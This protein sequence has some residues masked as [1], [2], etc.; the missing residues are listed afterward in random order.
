[1]LLT[2]G[3][4]GSA[5][6]AQ[7]LAAEL[8]EHVGLVAL[9]I[10]GPTDAEFV[11]R[12]GTHAG[13]EEFPNS[14]VAKQAHRVNAVV[15]AVEVSD[16]EDGLGARCPH[17][18]RRAGHIAHRA[19]IGAHMRAEDL[20]KLL[21]TTLIEQ[22]A[23]DLPDSRGKAVGVVGL[24]LDAI[25]PGRQDAIVHRLPDVAPQATPDTIGFMLKV[26][27]L[28]VLE[29]NAHRVGKR[30]HGPNAQAIRLDVLPEHIVGLLVA[31]IGQ[32]PARSG[33]SAGGSG[34]HGWSSLVASSLRK[35]RSIAVRGMSIHAGRLRAS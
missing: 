22:K 24:V 34:A 18:E 35:S 5:T 13:N 12:A 26:E 33:K 15:P 7:H 3:N 21:V 32:R 9:D 10:V 8:R 25:A 19:W 23:V 4:G 20:P 27:D 29:A 16:D 30:P 31:A 17:R 6:D 2:C 14:R 28:T 11:C 1:M